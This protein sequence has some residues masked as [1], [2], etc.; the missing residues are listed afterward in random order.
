MPSYAAPINTEHTQR[1]SARG[2]ILPLWRF[3]TSTLAVADVTGLAVGAKCQLPS[4]VH[5]RLNYFVHAHARCSKG[6][7]V[8]ERHNQNKL[9]RINK[10]KYTHYG[11]LSVTHRRITHQNIVIIF[12]NLHTHFNSNDNISCLR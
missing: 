1:G 11:L 2:G 7:C 3:G 4:A 8:P 10:H 5:T 6:A 9:K 12:I